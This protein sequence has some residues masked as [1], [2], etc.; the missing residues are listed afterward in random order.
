[1][2]QISS[3]TKQ[4]SVKAVY[5]NLTTAL[6][7]DAAPI[8]TAVVNNVKYR[9]AKAE[10]QKNGIN[11]CRTF[12]D[13]FQA[14]FSMVQSDKTSGNPLACCVIGTGDRM[15]SVILYTDSQ[16]STN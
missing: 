5:N 10:R 7:V 9:K 16:R 2:E 8:N 12:G 11:H 14:V 15:P 13:E 4:Q 6:D 1:M 3:L